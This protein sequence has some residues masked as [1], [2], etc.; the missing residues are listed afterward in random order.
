MVAGQ[1]VIVV[2]RVSFGPG[3]P[4]QARIA[5]A[6]PSLEIQASRAATGDI[7]GTRGFV[8]GDSAQRLAGKLQLRWCI[9]E[10]G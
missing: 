2:S 10:Q 5:R 4:G 3:A 9:N 8:A 1:P 7:V 6:S